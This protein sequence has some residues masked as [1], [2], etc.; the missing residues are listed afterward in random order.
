MSKI[1]L[2]ITSDAHNTGSVL[3][4]LHFAQ[5]A[6]AQQHDISVFFYADGVTLANHFT[7]PVSDELNLYKQWVKLSDEINIPL[8][9]CNTAATRRGVLPLEEKNA[10]GF[11]LQAPFVA[12]GLTEYATLSQKVDKAVQF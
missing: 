3:S 10:S 8:Y 6:I 7:A 11:N 4:A 12:A 2:V 9:V 1:L 5:A